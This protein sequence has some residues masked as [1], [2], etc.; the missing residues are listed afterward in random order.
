MIIYLIG[1]M[2]V[3]K[4]TIGRLLAKELN[5]EFIDTDDEIELREK[6][7]IN[8]IFK[9]KGEEY[10]RTVE[11]DIIKEISLRDNIIVSCGGGII[12]SDDNIDIMRS[13]G[14]VILLKAPAN[15]IYERIRDDNNRPLLKGEK[16]IDKIQ[17]L[18]D[19]RRDL[20]DKAYHDKVNVNDSAKRVAKRIANML[21]R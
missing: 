14:R 7:S 10:F 1:F 8:D 20:Y 5:Y 2:G 4:S 12:K 16:S 18:I 13:G 11:S 6:M 3:G 17:S 19:E 9:N 21:S 15:V